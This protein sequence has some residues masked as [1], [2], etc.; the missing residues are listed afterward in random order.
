MYLLH[1]TSII[2]SS[3]LSPL[4]VLEGACWKIIGVTHFLKR[5][6]S[7]QTLFIL[8][9]F[10][11]S[12][13]IISVPS[14]IA[15]ITATYLI[16]TFTTSYFTVAFSL[17]PPSSSI[18]A[19]TIDVL[20]LSFWLE[21]MAA[22]VNT[23]LANLTLAQINTLDQSAFRLKRGEWPISANHDGFKGKFGESLKQKVT[24]IRKTMRND[25][26]RWGIKKYQKYFWRKIKGKM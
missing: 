3:S 5:K 18:N 11:G 19:I 15:N 26:L 16:T 9:R 2:T 1:Y 12:A 6:K 23:I 22:C 21:Q 24:E 13:V 10:F 14:N 20:V 7:S 8:K 17:K 25:A 4:K